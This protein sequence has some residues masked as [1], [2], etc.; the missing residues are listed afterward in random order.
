[1]ADLG[2]V[3]ACALGPGARRVD[4]EEGLRL[5]QLGPSLQVVCVSCRPLCIRDGERLSSD[6]SGAVRGG[7]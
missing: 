3:A 5:P 6:V 7:S 4:V 2:S 1:M